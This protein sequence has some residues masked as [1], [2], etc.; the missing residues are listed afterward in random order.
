MIA[1]DDTTFAYLEGRPAAPKGD[2]ER[3]LER[4]S[5]LRTDDD[6]VF[7]REVE[8]DVAELEPQVT[9]GTNPGM[10]API[11]GTVPDPAT[12]VDPDERAA[13]QRALAYMALEPGTPLGRSTSTASSSARVRT[14]ASRICA[15]PRS[16]WT[17]IASTRE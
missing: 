17:D 3:A 5:E 14:P 10:V 8:I 6:A 15:R 16:W 13:T 7:D 2:W 1:P 4:W 12:I 11:G 9:W